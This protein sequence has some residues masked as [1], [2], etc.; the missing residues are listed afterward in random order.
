ML[1]FFI[2]KVGF[3][4]KLSYFDNKNRI[5]AKQT[6]NIVFWIQQNISTVCK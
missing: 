3:F 6:Q 4:L 2:L 5:T 1:L